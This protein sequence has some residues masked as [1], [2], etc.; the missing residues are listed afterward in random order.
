MSFRLLPAILL[1]LASFVLM[2]GCSSSDPAAAMRSNLSDA[3]IRIV[4]FEPL[5]GSYILHGVVVRATP[6][7]NAAWL[8]EEG[9]EIALRPYF[10]GD[11]PDPGDPDHSRLMTLPNVPAGSVIRCRI[12]MDSA[13]AWRILSTN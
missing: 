7:G 2:H 12:A 10:P 4:R 9:Q 8:A 3:E 13:G 11:R 1:A 5:T 6:V